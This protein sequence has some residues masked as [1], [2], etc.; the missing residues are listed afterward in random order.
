MVEEEH[1]QEEEVKKYPTTFQ[2]TPNAKQEFKVLLNFLEQSLPAIP[3]TVTYPSDDIA[4]DFEKIESDSGKKYPKQWS[5]T[6]CPGVSIKPVNSGILSLWRGLCK[7]GSDRSITTSDT[8]PLLVRGNSISSSVSSF[9]I[10]TSKSK[11]LYANFA[12]P[13]YTDTEDPFIAFFTKVFS[14]FVPGLDFSIDSNDSNNSAYNFVS[15]Q[16]YEGANSAYVVSQALAA[17]GPQPTRKALISFLRSNSNSLSSATF[18]PISYS[19]VSNVG[20]TVQYI[21]KFDGNK[22]VKVSDYYLVNQDGTSIR[23]VIPKR[24]PLLRDGIPSRK[25]LAK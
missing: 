4:I 1:H 7:G 12:M 19:S 20:D 5:A 22:W 25:V 21:G 17:L 3:I 11:N 16:M 6:I 18:S 14:D 10:A 23:A 15:Q 24:N 2:L 8:Y 9:I 13:F